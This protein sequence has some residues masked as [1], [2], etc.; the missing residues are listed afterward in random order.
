MVFLILDRVHSSPS[1][2]AAARAVGSCSRN[3]S[4]CIAGR[5]NRAQGHTFRRASQLEIAAN[6]LSFE[7]ADGSFR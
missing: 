1:I 2:A 3:V 4:A 5:R 7:V 6:G